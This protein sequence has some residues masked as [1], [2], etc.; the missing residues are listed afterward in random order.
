[1]LTEVV[2]ER[3]VECVSERSAVWL[4]L[5]DTDRLNR[6]A[7]M[8]RLAL[9]PFDGESAARFLIRTTLAGFEVSYEELPYEWQYLERFRV[10]RLMREGPVTQLTTS[11]AT[12]P[13]SAGGTRVTLRVAA[14][15]PDPEMVEMV[16]MS[17]NFS[18]DGLSTAVQQLDA[19]LQKGEVVLPHRSGAVNAEALERAR[20]ELTKQGHAVAGA[21]LA[22][23]ISGG[24]DDQ[25]AAIRPYAL[26]DQ[27]KLPRGQVLAASLAGVRAGLLELRWDLVCPSCRT[28]ST[29]VGSLAE[30]SEHGSCQLCDIDFG[31]D[32]DQSVEATFRPTAHVR[33][34]DGG[35]YCIG[36]PSRTPHVLA[37]AL[38]PAKGEAELTAP[39]EPGRYRLFVRGGETVLVEVE[40]GRAGEL[41]L[42][43]VSNEWPAKALVAPGAKLVIASNG[44]AARHVKLERVAWA[45][46]A[47]TARDVTLIP[48]FR[49][50]FSNQLLKPGLALKV[51][52][53]SLLFSDLTGST[54]LYSEAGDAAAFRLV[55]DHFDVLISAIEKR[56]GSVVKTIGDA[57]MAVFPDDAS[58]LAAAL[59]MLAVFETFRGSDALRARTHV[60]LGLFGGPTYVVTANGVLDYFGQTVNVAARLQGEAHS[61]EVV[62]PLALVEAVTDALSTRM[63]EVQ[64]YSAQLKGIEAPLPVVRL[65]ARS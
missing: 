10:Q 17:A 47:A 40:Q 2:V 5:A 38:L 19:Q 31:I 12:E 3:V 62:A 21:R 37:Q 25:V 43:E 7:G 27:W 65:R 32:L 59:D 44:P 30:L 56:G 8:E 6:A 11:F 51:A 18:L 20:L 13:T 14:T 9:E 55:L 34:V 54:A 53:V 36:G 23:L 50:D 58:A 15:T 22:E 64:R 29:T 4:A 46:Q 42:P 60:K 45:Q 57:I 1:M 39:L 35:P 41:R 33:P 28:G 49:R 24:A 61:G 26:A 52:R 16:Q 63:L 48:G